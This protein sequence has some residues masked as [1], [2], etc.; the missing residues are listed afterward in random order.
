MVERVPATKGTNAM[1]ISTKR[2]RAFDRQRTL[3]HYCGLPMWNRSYA[4]LTTFGLSRAEAKPHRC[5]AEHLD[6]RC[7]GG[8]NSRANIVAACRRCNHGRHERRPA[9]SPAKH[10]AFVLREVRAGRWHDPAVVAKLRRIRRAST[11]SAAEE[12]PHATLEGVKPH[13]RGLLHD[14]RTC[15]QVQG[16]LARPAP[17][18]SIP[19]RAL[20]EAEARLRAT[21]VIRR[22]V[23]GSYR[24]PAPSTRSRSATSTVTDTLRVLPLANSVRMKSA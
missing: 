1:S 21:A 17:D 15:C 5:T 3:C 22:M 18:R 19:W 14:P 12:L 2:T 4:E 16:G 9:L 10:R 8:G 7:D 11:G 13:P 6:P 20:Y 24:P 23:D